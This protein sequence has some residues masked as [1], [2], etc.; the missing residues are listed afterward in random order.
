MVQLN[1]I[2][3]MIRSHSHR[4]LLKPFSFSVVQI[5]GCVLESL[6]DYIF[7]TDL[8]VQDFNYTRRVHQMYCMKLNSNLIFGQLQSFRCNDCRINTRFNTYI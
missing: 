7:L 5:N 2:A 1:Y 6:I 4:R 8:H 3:H